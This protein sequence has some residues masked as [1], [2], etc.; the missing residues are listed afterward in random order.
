MNTYDSKRCRLGNVLPARACLEQEEG[1]PSPSSSHT[2]TP[3][4]LSP[5][6][7]PVFNIVTVFKPETGC[8]PR[9]CPPA[10]DQFTS[11]LPLVLMPDQ[12]RYGAS[13]KKKVWV[14]P[15]S[16]LRH[17]S[18]ATSSHIDLNTKASWMGRLRRFG[19]ASYDCLQLKG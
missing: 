5:P 12:H 16:K 3:E 15:K 4:A 8:I 14:R 19:G 2:M 13:E 1:D 18:M 6:K 10:R 17:V 9:A 11:V 7:L